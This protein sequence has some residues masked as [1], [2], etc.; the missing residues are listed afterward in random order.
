MAESTEEQPS[1]EKEDNNEEY[2]VEEILGKRISRCGR[3]QY[4][5]KWLGYPD[6]ENS[7]ED[8]DNLVN[9][10]ELVEQYEKKLI[11]ES[12]TGDEASAEQVENCEHVEIPTPQNPLQ[13]GYTPLEILGVTNV[14]NKLR[15]L[16][17]FKGL[18][19]A[20]FVL[21]KDA[22]KYCPDIVI[23]FYESKIRFAD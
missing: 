1:K 20:I 9:C 10:P 2:M 14:N 11:D 17:K 13:E 15:F 3:V 18:D 6:S 22:H 7:W 16:I 21:A 23:Q 4:L 12:R 5:L 19:E 8:E